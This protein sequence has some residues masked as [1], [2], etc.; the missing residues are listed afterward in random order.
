M[1][2]NTHHSK[3]ANPPGLRTIVTNRYYPYQTLRSQSERRP[4]VWVIIEVLGTGVN[5]FSAVTERLMVYVIQVCC[6]AF[7]TAG[8]TLLRVAEKRVS[9]RYLVVS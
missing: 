6:R 5:T 1:L 3:I 7:G 2:A 4:C 8:G 9:N